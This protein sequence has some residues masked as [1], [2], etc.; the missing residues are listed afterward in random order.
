[1]YEVNEGSIMSRMVCAGFPQEVIDRVV[2][3]VSDGSILTRLG[4]PA[5]TQALLA[6]A[7]DQS[8]LCQRGVEGAITSAVGVRQGDP[9]ASGLFV[10]DHDDIMKRICAE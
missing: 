6:S 5:P 10:L 2:E 1:M 7:H 9:I 4:V 8:W 3:F